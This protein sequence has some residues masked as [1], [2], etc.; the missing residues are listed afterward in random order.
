[1]HPKKTFELRL[2]PVKQDSY[3]AIKTK[4]ELMDWLLAHG[5]SAFVEGS[6]EVDVNHDYETTEDEYFEKFGGQEAPLSIYKFSFD[7]LDGLK[8]QVEKHYGVRIEASIH[9]MDTQVWQEG[10]KE[11][12][13]PFDTK[14]FNVRPPWESAQAGSPLMDLVIEPGMA[15]GTGQH[16]TTKLC[17]K[18]LEQM[19]F[20]S[21]KS[22]LDVGTGSGIL[23]IAA[24]KLGISQ[25]TGTDIE[26]DAVN[27]SKENAVTNSVNIG[28]EKGSVPSG[29]IYDYVFA[30]ILTVVLRKILPDI[31]AA[32]VPGGTVLL[33]GILNE[34]DDEMIGIAKEYGL[35]PKSA[36]Q[37][38]GWSCLTFIK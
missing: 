2:L 10:W 20:G 16:A 38:S 23:A 14:K 13:K 29:K 9:S 36:A 12:F 1:M 4:N 5:V 19:D 11:S 30:N 8:T 27:A 32:T 6:L 22:L 7:E 34:E 28:F 35:T 31:A 18:T 3:P 21:S 15:F 26:V 24:V 25:A 17:I 37:L 33:S